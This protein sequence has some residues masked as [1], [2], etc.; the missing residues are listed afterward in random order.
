MET[1]HF[2]KGLPYLHISSR[3][4]EIDDMLQTF[5][6]QYIKNSDKESF[7]LINCTSNIVFHLSYMIILSNNTKNT[8]SFYQIT[9]ACINI[10]KHLPVNFSFIHRTKRLKTKQTRRNS[11]IGIVEHSCNNCISHYN[12]KDSDW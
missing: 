3:L 4:K 7:H 12:K 10:M 11:A 5:I 6:V 1:T 8:I 2:K 9:I